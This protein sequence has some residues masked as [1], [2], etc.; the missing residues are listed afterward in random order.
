MKRFSE[1]VIASQ[2]DTLLDFFDAR[3]CHPNS[4]ETGV[5]ATV[6]KGP[7]VFVD[8]QLWSLPYPRD[9]LRAHAVATSTDVLIFRDMKDRDP[10]RSV[11]CDAAIWVGE[12][13]IAFS[14]SRWYSDQPK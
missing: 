14:D 7:R 4:V 5:E 11:R 12:H 9:A 1:Y 10:L 6:I 8:R 13:V 2:D 3:P